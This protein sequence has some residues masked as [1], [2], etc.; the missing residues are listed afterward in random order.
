MRP[1]A[2]A[3]A[4][5][6]HAWRRRRTARP[7]GTG[8]EVLDELVEREPFEQFHHVVKRAIVGDAIVIDR[9]RMR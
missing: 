7:G 9:Y 6:W 5:E 3:S 2:W 1:V 8:A 4:R